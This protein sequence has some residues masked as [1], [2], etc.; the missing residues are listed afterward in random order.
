MQQIHSPDL[1]II[2][3]EDP[4][5]YDLEGVGQIPVNVKTGMTFEKGLRAILRQDPD[6]IMVGEIRDIETAQV[7]V[8]ASLTGHRVFSTLHTNDAVGSITRLT[9]M[10]IEPYLVA[11]SLLGA[12][13]QRLVRK[14]CPDC[15]VARPPDA[16]E[17]GGQLEEVLERLADY[18]ESRRALRQSLSMSLIYP[19][20]LT[21][22]S[23]LVVAVL[24]IY[25]VPEVVR[26]FQQT[27]QPLPWLTASLIAT[28]N[29]LRVYGWQGCLT[30]AACILPG[31][32]PATLL[33]ATVAA[34]A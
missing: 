29:A 18:T 22:V 31:G 13:A 5:E 26:V 9:D 19:V 17:A 33:L 15:R 25:V 32:D 34:S 21:L 27:G 2:T 10:G 3:V 4:V 24:L 30:A 7:A 14:L 1:N 8:Q 12:L 20:I 11:S 28:S 6:V 23:L 16:G